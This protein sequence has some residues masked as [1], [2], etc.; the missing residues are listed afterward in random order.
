MKRFAVTVSVLALLGAAALFARSGTQTRTVYISA[1]DKKGAPVTDLTGT[2]L[3]VKED[4]RPQLPLKVEHATAPMRIAI[5]I[6]DGGHRSS[7]AS[8]ARA[9]TH[10]RCG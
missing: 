4:G 1:V 3:V 7:G 10:P 5:V 2:D 9:E 6:D 8:R